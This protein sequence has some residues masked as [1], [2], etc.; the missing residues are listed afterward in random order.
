MND[1]RGHSEAFEA[2]RAIERQGVPGVVRRAV[3]SAAAD[4]AAE[5]TVEFDQIR[6]AL[7][8]ALGRDEL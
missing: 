8:G 4:L 7:A 2:L 5:A 6:V 1:D 3:D